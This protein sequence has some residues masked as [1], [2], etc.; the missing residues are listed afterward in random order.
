MASVVMANDDVHAPAMRS[1]LRAMLSRCRVPKLR[2]MREFAEAEIVIPDGPYK[3]LRFSCRRQP[4]TRLMYDAIDSGAWNRFFITGPTQSGKSLSAWVVPIMYHLFE[5]GE[6]VIAAVPKKEMSADKWR[7]DLKP[8]IEASRYR[9]LL[10]RRGA[11]S[12]DGGELDAVKFLN[13]ATLKFMAGGGSDKA[14]AAFTS[15][16]LVITET[17]GMDESGGTSREADKI[18]QLEGRTRAYGSRKRVYSE[19]TVSIEAGRTWQEYQ[20][21]TASRIIRPC[22]HCGAWVTPE[23]ES[24]EGWKDAETLPAAKSAGRYVCPECSHPWTESERAASNAQAK[25]LHRGQEVTPE[26]EIVGRPIETDTLGFRWSAVDN[27]FLTAGDI[28]ADEWRASRA[29]DE[30]NAEKEM[31]QF[32]WCLPYKP[33]KSDLIDLDYRELV[34]RQHKLNRGYVPDHRT[35]LTMGVDVGKYRLHWTLI[36]WLQDGGGRIVDY[37]TIEVAS[38]SIVLHAAII[39]A[40]RELRDMADQGWQTPQGEIVPI[41]AAFVDAHYQTPTVKE[42]CRESG[43]KWMPSIGFGTGEYHDGG[44]AAKYGQPKTTGAHVR[45]LGER[46]HSAVLKGERELTWQFDADYWKSQTH[47]RLAC[48]EVSPGSLLLYHVENAIDHQQYCRHLTSEKVT[49]E[50]VPGKGE[51]VKWEK[52]RGSNHWFDSTVMATLAG[53]RCGVRMTEM[54]PQPEKKRRLTW[55]EMRKKRA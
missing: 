38:K 55:A 3:G 16:V 22:P 47:E 51:V 43:A 12:R 13:G 44:K 27:H 19:C 45:H 20:S 31:R 9:D 36:A 17:D 39:A 15:R 8:A 40:L 4:Y 35:C 42:F 34:K 14:R 1:A 48:P 41:T 30:E 6:T 23:R 46:Y 11:G 37:D 2:T 28:A 52:V 49:T 24:L 50:F 25:L 5:V 54:T 32:V 18:A 33:P 10:P 21:G 29:E 7:E 26:G 53:H